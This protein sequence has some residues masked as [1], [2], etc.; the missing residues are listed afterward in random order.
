MNALW[1]IILVA[2]ALVCTFVAYRLGLRRSLQLVAPRQEVVSYPSVTGS[3]P[4]DTL[5]LDVTGI[6]GQI[7][8]QSRELERLPMHAVLMQERNAEL[9]IGRAKQLAADVFKGA[10]SVPN[11]TIELAFDS[12]IKEGLLSGS[13]EI[14][15]ARGGGARLMARQVDSKQIAGHGRVIVGGS[16]RQLAAGAFHVLSIAVAQSH[17]ADINKNL[18]HIKSSVN[19]ITQRMEQ[20]EI[21]KFRGNITY[22]E[23]L[24]GFMR[25]LS[26]P[27]QVPVEKRVQLED[28]RRESMGLM[29][30]I[31]EKIRL[32]KQ[33]VEALESKD[34]AGSEGT[35][36]E[37]L[38]FGVQAARLIECRNL[39][40]RQIALLNIATIYLDPFARDSSVDFF[41][42]VCKESF[43]EAKSMTE[44]LGIRGGQLLK[45][46]FNTKETL[47]ERKKKIVDLSNEL[48]ESVKEYQQGYDSSAQLMA[49]HF[50]R[51][52]YGGNKARLA[53]GFDDRGDVSKV[54]LL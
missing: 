34:M 6:G 38:K 52:K 41:D 20:E 17:L 46:A 44:A 39:Y 28:I 18:E 54:A 29:E 37:L 32:L 47:N 4:S 23:Y 42:S 49:Q 40:L 22:L 21:G 36:N 26:S 7:L 43:Y 33:S 48:L 27:D 51:L 13:L 14:I 12:S 31:R 19:K 10:I 11:K 5:D 2:T 9:A 35:F 1:L 24:V 16:G 15:G 50:D 30:G 25:D 3:E 53:V 45:A 8:V